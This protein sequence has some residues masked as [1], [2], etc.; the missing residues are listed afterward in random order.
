[1]VT[2]KSTVKPTIVDVPFVEVTET[3]APQ[4]DPW[5]AAVHKMIDEA[6][7]SEATDQHIGWKRVLI[8]FIASIA[9]SGLTGYLVGTVIGY[10]LVGA[11]L[12]SGSLFITLA[13][14]LIGILMAMH[15]GRI[16]GKA[17]YDFIALGDIDNVYASAKDKVSDA[18]NTARG[19]F[20][21]EPVAA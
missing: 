3:A 2:R 17:T 1:M 20:V 13:I 7:D 8:A 21:T 11:I 9:T 10:A 15:F 5:R 12:L 14:Y 16:V 19:W 18:F 4:P 6:F